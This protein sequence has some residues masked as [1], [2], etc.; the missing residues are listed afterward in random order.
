MARWCSRHRTIV[1]VL[2]LVALAGSFGASRA[3]GT[4]FST[5]FQLPGTQSGRALS[6]LAKDFPAAS[7]S[8]DQIILHATAG[9]LR[10]PAVKA[11]AQRMLRQVAV[12]PHVRAV[13]S[14]FS[15]A[16]AGQISGNATV[17][18]ATVSF[19]QQSQTLPKAAA[20][21]VITTGEAAGGGQLQVA[22]GGQDIENAQSQGSSNSTLAGIVLALAVLGVAFGA[23][24]AAFLP[25][26]TALAAVGVGYFVAG[27]LSHVFS[28]AS[29]ATILGVLIGLGVGVDYALLIITRHRN[30]LKAG[31]DVEDATVNAVNTAGGRCSS[32]G[33][34]CVSPCSASSPWASRSCTASPSPPRSPWP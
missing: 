9:T 12:L 17:A 31:H 34:R 3:A 7:G 6:L 22:L 32:P 10:D 5:Q 13:A 8:S 14:P 23:L 11:R 18:F 30:G 25:L 29:F 15:A 2:W 27:L 19:D 21:H 4:S 28:V 20:Q 33:S 16:G 26:I 24:F 1:L